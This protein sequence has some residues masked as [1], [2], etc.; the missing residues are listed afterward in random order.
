MSSSIIPHDELNGLCT[1]GIDERYNIAFG[2]V[3][4]HSTGEPRFR[5]YNNMH[6]CDATA[7]IDISLLRAKAFSCN[8]SYKDFIPDRDTMRFLAVKMS[9][10]SRIYPAN[11]Y[12]VL[13][14]MWNFQNDFI[15]DDQVV[16]GHVFED[17]LEGKFDTVENCGDPRYIPS[18]YAGYESDWAI[19]NWGDI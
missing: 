4:D 7:A 8:K 2:I 10:K 5:L 3:D 1:L 6:P 16:A 19:I 13:C 17:Y 18:Y 14:C 9:R 11:Y 12:Q 15:T